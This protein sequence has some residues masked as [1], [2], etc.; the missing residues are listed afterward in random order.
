LI[1]QTQQRDNLKLPQ[2]A[3]R[4]FKDQTLGPTAIVAANLFIA[5]VYF[6]AAHLSLKL[7]FINQSVSPVW[8]PSGLAI[9]SC[10]LLGRRFLPGIYLGAFVANHIAGTPIL[11]SVLIALGN[12]LEAAFGAFIFNKVY[13]IRGKLEDLTFLSGLFLT[14]LLAPIMSASIGAA[15]LHFSGL[16]TPG[17]TSAIWFTWWIGDALGIFMLLPF[18][19][20]SD[21]QERE[22]FLGLLSK[23]DLRKIS[24]LILTVACLFG[25]YHLL[26]KPFS[27]K[28]LFLI[29]TCVFVFSALQ[30]R[31]YLFLNIFLLNSVV[32][33]I[34][35]N[36][37]GPFNSSITNQNLLHLGIFLCTFI[38]VSAGIASFFRTQF[39][40]TIQTTML[41]GLAFWGVIFFN[42][43]NAN[44]AIDQSKIEKAISEGNTKIENTFK[45]YVGILTGGAA[46]FMASK[47][48]DAAEWSDYVDHLKN[49]YELPGARGLG[50]V[51]KVNSKNLPSF[52]SKQQRETSADFTIKQVPQNPNSKPVAI[53]D[54][55]VITYIEP[56]EINR[57]ARGLD[58]A[59]EEVRAKAA[60]QSIVSGKPTVTNTIQLVQ[61]RKKHP[62]FLIYLPVY[63]KHTDVSTDENRIKNFSH[64]IYSPVVAPDFFRSIAAGLSETLHLEI[65]DED[66][67]SKAE[68]LFKDSHVD[69]NT[70]YLPHV[71]KIRLGEKN[72]YLKWQVTRKLIAESDFLSTWIGL[73]GATSVLLLSIFI[74]SLLG[75][76]EK[77]QAI[78]KKL[79]EEFVESEKKLKAHEAKI[80]ESAKMAS[81]GEMAGGIAHEIN[82][83]LAIISATVMQLENTLKKSPLQAEHE[84]AH[85]YLRRLNSTVERISKI[86][87]NRRHFARDGENDPMTA[88]SLNRVIEDTLSLCAERFRNAEIPI[89][90]KL[91]YNGNLECRDIQISQVM[92]NLLGN[93]FDAI[94]SLPEKWVRIETSASGGFVT[95]RVTDSGRGIPIDVQNKMLNPFY[96]TK[97]VGKGTGLGL[98]LSKGIVESHAGKLEIDNSK[99]NTTFVVVLPIYQQNSGQ[100]TAA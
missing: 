27:L 43:Q 13:A 92:L 52:T 53:E 59:S 40:R 26:I 7:A 37:H 76:K 55:F 47:N 66:P 21:A 46:L 91:D 77:A 88:V 89:D 85:Q 50:V 34:T 100:K 30:N 61:D 83:P 87:K 75:I 62:G 3:F 67:N 45:S 23:P 86:I 28:F 1:E 48:V 58:L 65:Y 56:Y 72:F 49:Y 4:L 14:S 19:Y 10:I 57:E 33:L 8:P 5:V 73:V 12:T 93:A 79:N 99:P 84:K 80:I 42:V 44:L 71:S 41:V 69:L 38:L 51:Y 39:N 81:L 95:I 31:I 90:L 32:T 18:I 78:A 35:V 24:I 17:A 60:R 16:I 29:F 94:E 70:N 74:V 11:A 36:G 96:T 54:H 82:N 15:T 22:H 2:Q 25:A 20:F 63:K 98:S 97:A 9:L 64:W 68:L 6:L